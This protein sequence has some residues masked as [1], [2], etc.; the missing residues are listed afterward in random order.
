MK[1]S[2]TK[3]DKDRKKGK[4]FIDS[5]SDDDDDEFIFHMGGKKSA[6]KIYFNTT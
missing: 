3:S 1:E 5:D 4:R 2:S 6:S